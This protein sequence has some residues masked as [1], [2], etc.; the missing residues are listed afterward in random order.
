[1][2][3]KEYYASIEVYKQ[4]H[5]EHHGILGMKWGV[6]RYLNYDGTLTREGARRVKEQLDVHDQN[7]KNMKTLGFDKK[8]V[9]TVNKYNKKQISDEYDKLKGL[10]KIDK[11][12]K[13]Y[14]KG[15]RIG[16]HENT[17]AGL[18][19]TARVLGTVG[20][21]AFGLDYI[22]GGKMSKAIARAIQYKDISRLK[23][24]GT[25]GKIVGAT[26][27]SSAA[28]SAVAAGHRLYSN[29]RNDLLRNYYMNSNRYN[30]KKEKGILDKTNID[31][32]AKKIAKT[33]FYF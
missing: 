7:Q 11:G 33:T 19:R 24:S 15:E 4:N 1:M 2:D 17:Q 32:K 16:S 31:K 3:R 22:L 13:L 20:S 26:L 6:R 8:S 21:T 14:L 23:N 25:I 28:V 29:H 9:R 5:L 12:Q 10:K 18:R 27:A 30:V